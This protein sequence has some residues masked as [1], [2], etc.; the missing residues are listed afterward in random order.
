MSDLIPTQVSIDM[1]YGHNLLPIEK[2]LEL[3]LT[4]RTKLIMDN[5]VCFLRGSA[6]VPIREALTLLKRARPTFPG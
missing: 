3:P 2:W 4:K 5:R 1:G 6:V